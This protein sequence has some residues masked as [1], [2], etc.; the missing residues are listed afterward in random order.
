MYMKMYVNIK[1]KYINK[2]NGLLL[3]DTKYAL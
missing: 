3:F 1:F 2:Y